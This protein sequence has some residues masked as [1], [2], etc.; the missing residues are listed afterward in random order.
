MQSA[1]TTNLRYPL[2]YPVGWT[3]TKQP[4]QT[5]KYK[6]SF[7]QARDEL[8]HELELLSA[9]NIIISSNIPTRNDG[10][11]YANW[12]GGEPKD[13]GVAIYFDLNRKPY[14]LACDHWNRVRDNLREIGL[15]ICAMRDLV[16]RPVGSLQQVF[17]GFQA[18]PPSTPDT[19]WR[20][21]GVDKDADLETIKA[22][23]RQ[24]ARVYHSDVGGSDEQ[25][26]RLNAAWAQAKSQRRFEE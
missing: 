21:L 15:Y 19:W 12:K 25:M 17:A 23:Y 18:L 24:K 3:R 16:N 20:I 11:P 10:L 1:M 2:H 7:T 13:T 6:V 26:V 9:T 14:A 4:K 5:Y 22:A 8:L